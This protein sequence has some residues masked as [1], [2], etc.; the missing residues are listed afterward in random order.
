MPSL[1]PRVAFSQA[2]WCAVAPDDAPGDE[3]S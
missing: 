3:P 2:F 1:L